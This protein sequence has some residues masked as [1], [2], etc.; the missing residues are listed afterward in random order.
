M[1]D[2]HT[3]HAYKE[4]AVDLTTSSISIWEKLGITDNDV[5]QYFTKK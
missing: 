3:V 1:S 2:K 4:L 5:V